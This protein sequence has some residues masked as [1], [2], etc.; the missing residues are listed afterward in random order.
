ME[1]P[2]KILEYISSRNQPVESLN[3]ADQFDEDHQK[4]VGAIKSLESLG[5]VIRTEQKS[6]KRWQLTAE[7]SAF[8]KRGSHEAVVYSAIPQ[9]GQGILQ[10]DLMKSVGEAI[11]EKGKVGFS[12]ALQQGWIYIDK[13]DKGLVKRKVDAISDTVQKDLA[14]ISKGSDEVPDKSLEEYKKRKLLQELTVKRYAIW[15]N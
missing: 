14:A 5:D 9:D 13:A 6:V 15:Q 12:K 11:G 2:E 7:G 8:V 4:V 3:L 10:P 1:L